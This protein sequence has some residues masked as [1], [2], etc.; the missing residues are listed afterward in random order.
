MGGGILSS[1]KETQH[2]YNNQSK[3]YDLN[4]LDVFR[5]PYRIDI[6]QPI[7]HAIN[8]IDDLCDISNMDLISLLEQARQLGLYQAN[9]PPKIKKAS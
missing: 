6:I 9:Y 3:I 5:T 7:Y 4:V 1:P 8:G 2:I